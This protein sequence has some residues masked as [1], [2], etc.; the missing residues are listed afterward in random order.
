MACLHLARSYTW[1]FRDNAQPGQ[2][3]LLTLKCAA[4]GQVAKQKRSGVSLHLTATPVPQ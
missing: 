3:S 2:H 4:F 1:D